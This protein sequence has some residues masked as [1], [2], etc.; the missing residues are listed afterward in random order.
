M[1]DRNKGGDVRAPRPVDS[2]A[3]APRDGA[4]ADGDDAPCKKCHGTGA[5]KKGKPC[6]RCGGSGVWRRGEP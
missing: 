2:G 3:A 6:A 1:L 4:A 5:V